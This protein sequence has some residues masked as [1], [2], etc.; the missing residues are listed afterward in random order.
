MIEQ[1]IEICVAWNSIDWVLSIEAYDR[2][3]W[4]TAGWVEIDVGYVGPND[5]R[6]QIWK[7]LEKHVEE[8]S[9]KLFWLILEEACD[10]EE[11]VSLIE[12]H[13]GRALYDARYERAAIDAL[14]ND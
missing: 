10:E 2:D 7:D 6:G 5:I 12:S 3:N 9:D 13:R 11:V 14:Y 1:T 8:R 4:P